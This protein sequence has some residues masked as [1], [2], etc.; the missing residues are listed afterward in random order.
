MTLLDYAEHSSKSRKLL[1]TAHKLVGMDF[2]R[3]GNRTK[4]MKHFR[5]CL[6]TGYF[7]SDYIWASAFLKRLE[8][9][10]SWPEWTDDDQ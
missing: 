9:D 2:L 6:N 4:A 8:R 10:M 7:A 1:A 3:N 5:E